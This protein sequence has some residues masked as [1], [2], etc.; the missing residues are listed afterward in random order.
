M[1]KSFGRIGTRGGY[2]EN[3]TTEMMNQ[4]IKLVTG[5]HPVDWFYVYRVDYNGEVNKIIEW[6]K[7]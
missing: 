2:T 5:E 3:E 4:I 7:Q 1:F 6:W